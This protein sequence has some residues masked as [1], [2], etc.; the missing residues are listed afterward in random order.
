MEDRDI[1]TLEK[2]NI[3]RNYYK[4]LKRSIH[5]EKFNKIIERV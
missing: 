2:L 5:L 4:I 3:Q 1:K